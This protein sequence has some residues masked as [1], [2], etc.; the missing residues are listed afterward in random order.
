M[1]A[2][3]GVVLVLV[4]VVWVLQGLDAPFAPQSFIT[5]SAPWVIWGS[6]AVVAGA[7]ILW[8][9]RKSR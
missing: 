6:L 4:G 5:G 7:A 3:L 9:D 2:A 8:W 1:R